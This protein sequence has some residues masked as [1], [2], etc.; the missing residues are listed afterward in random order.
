MKKAVIIILS[1]LALLNAL[2]IYHNSS[3]T[4]VDS[5]K[6]SKGLSSQI[7]EITD[8]SY[9]DKEYAQQMKTVYKT[10]TQL[11]RYAHVIEFATLAFLLCLIGLIAPTR[12]GWM[13]LFTAVAYLVSIGYGFL[14]EWHQI[15]VDG[16]AFSRNDIVSDTFGCTIGMILAVLVYSVYLIIKRN[17]KGVA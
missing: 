3:Q 7:V 16:R 2:F 15:F 8:K 4:R 12:A 1:V 17:K 13:T 6:I 11:R 9:A 14:D 10:E 5:R